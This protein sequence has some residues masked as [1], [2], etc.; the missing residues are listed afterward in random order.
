MEFLRVLVKTTLVS[1][2]R[3]SMENPF[4]LNALAEIRREVKGMNFG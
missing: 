3:N 4:N 2:Y 1:S